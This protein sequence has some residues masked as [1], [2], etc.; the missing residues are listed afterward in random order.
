MREKPI[1]L[2]DL[3]GTLADYDQ[4]MRE[5]LRAM[6]APGETVS[7]V[8][9]DEEPPH[10]HARRSA[11]SKD[12]AFWHGLKI[13]QPGMDIWN[14]TKELGF[15]HKILTKGPTSSLVAWTAKA[16]WVQEH[17]GKEIGI[18]VTTDKSGEYG[19]ILCDDWPSYILGWLE[20]RPRGLVVM[21]SHPWNQD[22]THPQVIRYTGGK[23]DAGNIA[24]VRE[25]II[26]ARDRVI[27][28]A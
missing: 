13:Y 22:F 6:M 1:A 25:R 17:L 20:H 15:R 24:E 26:L 18:S 10:I 4:S 27:E 7:Y 8:H 14:L 19:R 21:P 23:F 2:F 11:V 5:R 9:S 16:E 12:P 3:D 28:D